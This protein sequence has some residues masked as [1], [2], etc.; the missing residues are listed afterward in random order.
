MKKEDLEIG[1]YYKGNCRNASE[2]RWNGRVFVYWRTKFGETFLEEIEH[3]EDDRG[4]DLFEVEKKIENPI[5][6]IPLKAF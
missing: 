6:E 3:P 4:F 2:A 5:K 1:A